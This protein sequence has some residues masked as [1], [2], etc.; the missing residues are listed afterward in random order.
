MIPT[1]CWLI[2]LKLNF[3]FSFSSGMSFSQ[4][5]MIPT[6][7]VLSNIIWISSSCS[8][9]LVVPMGVFYFL[10]FARSPP[11]QFWLITNIIW[12]CCSHSVIP[13]VG[14]DFIFPI[15]HDPHHDS[16]DEYNLDFKF[17]F[18]FFSGPHEDRLY[19]G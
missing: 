19:I 16:V 8:P 3:M 17:M 15:S 1:M 14:I 4:L 10:N 12:N 9:F 5:R 18:S 11:W 2:F 7:T 13:R 6:T